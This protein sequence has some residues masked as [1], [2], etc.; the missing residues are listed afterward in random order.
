MFFL[1]NYLLIV[2]GIVVFEVK[3]SGIG[4]LKIKIYFGV[5]LRGY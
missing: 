1:S 2:V 4:F 3:V 5:V